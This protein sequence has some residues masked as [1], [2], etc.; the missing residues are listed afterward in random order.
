MS[1]SAT[2]GWLGVAVAALCWTSFGNVQAAAERRHGLSVFGDLKYAADFQYFDYVNPEA[3]KGGL[4]RTRAYGTFDSLHPFI[5]KGKIGSGLRNQFQRDFVG[6]WE[7][8]MVWSQDEPD[9]VYGLIAESVTIADDGVQARF[10]LRPQAAFHDGRP[11]TAE[12]V[13]FS[14]ETL[15]AKGHPRFRNL[16]RDVAAVTAK[17]PGIVG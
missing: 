5:L 17:E 15:K 16:L 4:F 8:L 3:P 11:I 10:Y 2:K 1:G 13:V 14:F 12:D 6:V 9:A 7:S